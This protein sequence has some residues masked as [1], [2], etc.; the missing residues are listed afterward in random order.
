MVPEWAAAKELL[1]N[2]RSAYSSAIEL[3]A[4]DTTLYLRR[5]EI[6]TSLHDGKAVRDYE[7]A[8][9]A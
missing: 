6:S 1:A 2:S 5:G 7:K 8:A 9:S 4:N 3:K